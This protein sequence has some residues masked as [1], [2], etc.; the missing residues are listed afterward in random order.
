MGA[1]SKREARL[2]VV[3]QQGEV[4]SRSLSGVWLRK[5]LSS[6]LMH[7][8]KLGLLSTGGYEELPKLGYV[9]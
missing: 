8:S 5:Q 3:E 2:G 1:L 6:Q 4:E 7:D 9:R